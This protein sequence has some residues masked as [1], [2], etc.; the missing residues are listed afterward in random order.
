[1]SPS[2]TF[3]WHVISLHLRVSF[4]HV[5]ILACGRLADPGGGHFFTLYSCRFNA[6]PARRVPHCVQ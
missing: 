5:Y 4:R 2:V 1:M 6:D 3:T